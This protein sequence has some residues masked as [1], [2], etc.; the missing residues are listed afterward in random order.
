MLCISILAVTCVSASL[1]MTVPIDSGAY[2]TTL[3]L[4]FTTDNA[5]NITNITCMYNE[6]GGATGT[7]LSEALN[8]TAGQTAWTDTV[9][10]S[11]LTDATTYNISCSA[12][13]GTTLNATAYASSVTFDSTDA[14]IT[15]TR[16][17]PAFVD[18]M[19]NAQLTCS[20]TDAIDS[21]VTMTRSLAKPS[22][23][24]VSASTSPYT[25]TGG[26]LNQI[27]L[28]TFTC[29]GVD[30]AGNS[31]SDTV[32]FTVQS[33]D[34]VINDVTD[35]DSPTSKNTK[36]LFFLLIIAIVV[37]IAVVVIVVNFSSKK[38]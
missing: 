34:D 25:F 26:D 37:V 5:V 2:T 1:T 28:Y 14:V 17:G 32:T 31:A 16:S 7:F 11:G 19:T 20:A 21:S 38:K 33:D 12:Y 36:M 27:G 9:T 13:N 30:D 35:K 23:A 8:T 6:T 15:T 10:I 29:T 18:F 4:A 24:T 22:G 3:N